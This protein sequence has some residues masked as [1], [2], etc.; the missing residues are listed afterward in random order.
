[1]H[2]M[3]WL[4]IIAAML[5][6]FGY[7]GMIEAAG[8]LERV[9]GDLGR[10]W[11]ITEVAHKPFPSGRAT[12]GMLDGFM[13]LQAE[14]GFSASDILS[15][16][17]RIP[18]LT[19]HLIGR[20]VTDD[21]SANYARLCGAYV[22]ACAFLR[23]KLGIDDFSEA[24]RHDPET[25]ALGRRIAAVVDDNP[26]PNALTPVAVVVRL[27]D[28]R[29]LERSV[30]TV[31]GNPAKPMSREAHLAKFC[32]NFSSSLVLLPRENAD[33]LISL[34]DDIE[35]VEDVRAIGDLLMP[36]T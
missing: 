13:E 25:L 5:A 23:G 31:Y 36:S 11:R 8:D 9:L 3:R 2:E 33:R 20:P 27:R 26:D 28:G 1:M 34:I 12:H 6:A 10:I 21:M 14:H 18:P 30:G 29:E 15:A 4:P 22:S 24:R 17:A 19:H 16:E 7:F 35:H 32:G